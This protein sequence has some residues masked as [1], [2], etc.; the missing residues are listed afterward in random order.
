MSI[1]IDV[2]K[3]DFGFLGV[4]IDDPFDCTWKEYGISDVSNV[5]LRQWD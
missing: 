1:E 2:M 4:F 3:C 5:G